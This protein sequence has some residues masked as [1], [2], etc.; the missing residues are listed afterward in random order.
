M[1]GL[2]DIIYAIDVGRFRVWLLRIA[3]VLMTMA[4]AGFYFF[5]HFRGYNNSEAMDQAQLARQIA[6]GEGYTTKLIRPLAVK[7][8]EDFGVTKEQIQLHNFPDTVN[9]PLYPYWLATIFKIGGVRL[10]IEEEDIKTLD[11]FAPEKLT[12]ILNVLLVLASCLCFYIWMVRAFDDRVAFL[13]TTLFILSDIL[14]KF[15]ISGL[16]VPLLLLMV[17]ALGLFVNEAI[18]AEEEEKYGVSIGWMAGASVLAGLM[19]L[20]RYS[21]IS[22]AV[23]LVVFAYFA[24]AKKGVMVSITLTIIAAITFPWFIRNLVLTGNPVGLS[25]AYIFADNGRLGGEA[26]WRA[27]GDEAQVAY[28]LRPLIRAL[29]FGMRGEFLHLPAVIGSLVGVILYGASLFHVF[30]RN[31]VRCSHWFWAGAFGMAFLLNAFLFREGDSA[32]WLRCNGMVLFLPVC[33][34]FGSA[35]FFNLIDRANLP[36]EILIYPIIFVL[37]LV[38]AIPLGVSL[39]TGRDVRF[40]FPYPPYY[41]HAIAFTKKWVPEKGLIVSDIPWATAWYQDRVSVWL[42]YTKEGYYRV[43]DFFGPVNSIFTTPYSAD[44]PMYSKIE[45][46]E[47]KAW[48]SLIRRT[49][50]SDQPLPYLLGLYPLKVPAEKAEYLFLSDTKYW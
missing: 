3:I 14:W 27:M 36:S 7:Q 47:Y 38:Q 40:P 50:L 42:P 49:N 13:A 28:G 33:L 10:G 22:L 4:M 9:P 44:R 17:T 46:G 32:S 12:G 5:Q 8:F 39:K 1:P 18:C 26:L 2:Q 25:M 19:V 43:N 30:R 41:P 21:M 45:K 29:I 15:S 34:G 23:A 6:V 37:C 16:S 20:T 48:E 11:I 35:F 24:F 31:T